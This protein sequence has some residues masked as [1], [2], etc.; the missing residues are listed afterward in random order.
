MWLLRHRATP[1]ILVSPNTTI[2]ISLLSRLYDHERGIVRY[3]MEFVGRNA[4]P[5]EWLWQLHELVKMQRQLVVKDET[6]ATLA[7]TNVTQADPIRSLTQTI[8]H[9]TA[10]ATAASSNKRPKGP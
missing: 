4:S 10:S 1:S 6:N 2:V 9:L 7:Q 5:P 3:I 8:A